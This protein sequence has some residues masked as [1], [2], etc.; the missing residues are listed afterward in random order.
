VPAA[1][2]KVSGQLTNAYSY[3]VNADQMS[4]LAKALGDQ[5]NATFFDSL[6]D[7]L[8][9]QFHA[10]FYSSSAEVRRLA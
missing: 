6:T 10:A 4:Q 1:Q 7:D 9:K 5:G 2:P 3:I 8:R